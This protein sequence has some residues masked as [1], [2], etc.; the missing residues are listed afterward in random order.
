[1][2]ERLKWTYRMEE[3]YDAAVVQCGGL[4][5]AKP[6]GVFEA[7]QATGEFPELTLQA[8]KWHLQSH[9]RRE[10]RE[11]EH[12]PSTEI[13]WT[14]RL[15]QLYESAVANL[16]G[17]WAAKPKDIHAQLVGEFPDLTVQSTKWHL[18]A[19]R[20]AEERVRQRQETTTPSSAAHQ[21]QD[22]GEEQ[23][24]EERQ[25]RSVARAS[26]L[27]AKR[28]QSSRQRRRPIDEGEEEEDEEG[29]A[30]SPRMP[31]QQSASLLVSLPAAPESMLQDGLSPAAAAAAQVLP[32]LAWGEVQSGMPSLLPAA[33]PASEQQPQQGGQ[34]VSA[35]AAHSASLASQQQ[36]QQQQQQSVGRPVALRP[37]HAPWTVFAYAAACRALVHRQ[38]RVQFIRQV[39]MALEQQANELRMVVDGLEGGRSDASSWPSLA[40]FAIQVCVPMAPRL[41]GAAVSQG[42][43]R[44]AIGVQ[45]GVLPPELLVAAFAF[46]P[47]LERHSSLALVCCEW[48]ELVHSP[49]LLGSLDITICSAD[50]GRLLTRLRALA[51]WMARKAAGQV[52]Q[53]RLHFEAVGELE[54]AERSEP[55]VLVAVAAVAARS[56]REL[57]VTA[58]GVPLTPLGPW[59]ALLEQLTSLELSSNQDVVHVSGFLHCLS[60][61]RHL[62]L[63]AADGAVQMEQ[64]GSL[65]PGLTSLFVRSYNDELPQ[66]RVRR[67]IADDQ[68][69]LGEPDEHIL[70]QAL[71]QLQQL[72]AVYLISQGL[73]DTPA[74][75]SSLRHLHTVC[76]SGYETEPRPLP[77][78]PWLAGLRR[79]A[80]SCH[81]LSDAASLKT[82][83]AARHLQRLGLTHTLQG[84]G[85]IIRSVKGRPGR[86]LYKVEEVK[87]V[88]EW[89][90]RHASLQHLAMQELPVDMVGPLAAARRARPGLTIRINADVFAVACDYACL[91]YKI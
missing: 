40:S 43:R 88:L 51:E 71:P 84:T 77:G 13:K 54:D 47:L 50:T 36:Q 14:G 74:A 72:T 25:Q 58:K 90:Q 70:E 87:R 41:R 42:D 33:S 37:Q 31:R 28:R 24:Q 53:L 66:V 75:L 85:K 44:S 63:E 5:A 81:F 8:V 45:I 86:I 30:P 46:A 52:Q 80:L 27:G 4:E 2:A 38:R 23:E 18:Y 9:R 78:G 35:A 7:M 89:A 60:E 6:K 73:P 15:E 16:G 79:L 39:V 69:L 62:R 55:A 11:R 68:G 17:I 22:E 29:E 21:Q 32:A 1:M 19:Q 61:L 57:S 12:G 59:L 67:A 26:R 20:R 10:A 64:G 49:E 91:E 34:A 65:P 83:D 82:L 56:L 76:W 3:A 48:S